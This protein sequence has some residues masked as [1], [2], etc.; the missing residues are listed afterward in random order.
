MKDNKFRVSNTMK[1]RIKI[2]LIGL[3][4]PI[5]IFYVFRLPEF[6]VIIFSKEEINK[7]MRVGRINSLKNDFKVLKNFTRV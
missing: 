7:I 1:I 5:T 3:F 2:I 4:L 6:Y